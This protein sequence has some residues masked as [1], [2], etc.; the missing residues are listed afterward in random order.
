MTDKCTPEARI[1]YEA[2]VAHEER[3]E[4]AIESYLDGWSLSDLLNYA[5]DMMVDYY[6]KDADEEEIATLLEECGGEDE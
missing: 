2:Q 3:I 6:L 1:A 5:Q 4:K